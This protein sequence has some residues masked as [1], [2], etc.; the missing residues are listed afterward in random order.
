MLKSKPSFDS[1]SM[2]D[3]VTTSCYCC[4]S[5]TTKGAMVMLRWREESVLW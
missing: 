1:L 5:N 3:V 4:D 2:V